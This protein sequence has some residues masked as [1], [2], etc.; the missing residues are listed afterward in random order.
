MERMGQLFGGRTLT[1]RFFG[2]RR[3]TTFERAARRS[4]CQGVGEEGP[5]KQTN[6]APPT[7]FSV[8]ES[9]NLFVP[10]R[11]GM[12]WKWG[13]CCG[14]S[15]TQ[16][17][18]MSIHLAWLHFRSAP[19][20]QKGAEEKTP[21]SLFGAGR[22]RFFFGFFFVF[23]YVRTRPENYSLILCLGNMKNKS[24]S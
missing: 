10:G 1:N 21:L 20:S 19:L 6:Y 24:L 16:T 23:G 2:L 8:P 9:N 14:T 3:T 15:S 17:E 12:G 5:K 18:L 13:D 11:D 22:K 4:V 7:S